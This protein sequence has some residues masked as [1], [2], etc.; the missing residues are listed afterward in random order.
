MD[1]SKIHI[2]QNGKI[3]EFAENQTNINGLGV[4]NDETFYGLNGEYL[5]KL[6]R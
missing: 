4:R 5:K 2:F 6:L 1:K 3:N